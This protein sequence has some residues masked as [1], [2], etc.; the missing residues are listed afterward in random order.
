MTTENNEPTVKEK[1][2]VEYETYR[3]VLD[4]RKADQSRA[5]ELQAE[6]DRIKAEREEA[7]AAKLAEQKRFEELY[8]SERKKSED[9]TARIKQA[10]TQSALDRKRA[11]IKTALGGVRKDE[12]LSFADLDSIVI[13]ENGQLDPDTVKAA[14]NKFREAHPEL[15]ASKETSRLPNDSATGFQ[16]PKGKP[17]HEHSMAELGAML[18]ASKK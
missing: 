13:L 18:A 6:L 1:E 5:R 16:P 17:L 8:A 2:L 15:V 9:L 3:R 4:Q 14:A 7:E 10:E 12:Y 11:A